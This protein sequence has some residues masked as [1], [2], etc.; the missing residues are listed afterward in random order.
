MKRLDDMLCAW[1]DSLLPPL[2]YAEKLSLSSTSNRR[3]Q[4]QPSLLSFGSYRLGVHNPN[5]DIDCLVLAPPHI[6]RTDFFDSWI[7]VLKNQQQQ[8]Q[9]SSSSS[10]SNDSK[11]SSVITDI[12]PVSTAY[13]PVVKFCMDGIKID[14]IF[15]R[16]TNAQLNWLNE[17]RLVRLQQ[18]QQQPQAIAAGQPQQQQQQ[19]GNDENEQQQQLPI[20]QEVTEMQV[21]DDILFGLDETSA[22]SVNGV[23]VSQYLLKCVGGS[24]GGSGDDRLDNFRLTLRI[25]KEWARVHGLY[26]NV[27]GFLGG[28]K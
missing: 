12:H 22:R 15:A 19:L 16:L 23:R 26:S 27:L 20:L 17:C 1:S 18:Q 2:S 21:N 5:A 7:T 3:H 14:M 28:V 6:Q 9:S 11:S 8:Q 4:Q 24:S 13:T 10:S 25:V